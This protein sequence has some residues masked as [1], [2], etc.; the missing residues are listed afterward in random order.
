[1]VENNE[2]KSIDDGLNALPNEVAAGT[3]YHFHYYIYN[4]PDTPIVNLPMPPIAGFQNHG[5]QPPATPPAPPA[6]PAPQPIMPSIAGLQNSGFQP[7]PNAQLPVQAPTFPQMAV[8]PALSNTVIGAK[9]L[10]VKTAIRQNANFVC[11]TLL[12]VYAITLAAYFLPNFLLEMFGGSNMLVQTQNIAE[13]SMDI[14]AYALSFGIGLIILKSWLKIPTKIAFPAQMRGFSITFPAIFVCLGIMIFGSY[15]TAYIAEFFETSAGIEL[16]APEFPIPT[17]GIATALYVISI[18]LL[19]AVLEELLFRGIIM[20]SL[21]RYGDGFALIVSAVLFSLYHSNLIQL[22]PTLLFGLAIGYFVMRTGSVLT[23]I[24][25]HMLN[26][27]FIVMIE[28]LT[29]GDNDL[30]IL[31]TIAYNVIILS[32]GVISVFFLFWRCPGIFRMAPPPPEIKLG[33][34]KKHLM[35][36]T[37]A[38][39]IVLVIVCV[40]FV[41]LGFV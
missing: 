19:P 39:S 15:V 26:N 9:L 28:L 14:F 20:Q 24:L 17:G 7:P 29:N 5:F 10:T 16:P 36:F 13:Q 8:A 23:G 22:L 11:G 33:K 18:V 32:M 34:G 31:A 38:C 25:I 2:N 12:L 37:S 3:Q 27:G 41:A 21:R 30:S 6:P 40:G 35:F 1:M 4:S